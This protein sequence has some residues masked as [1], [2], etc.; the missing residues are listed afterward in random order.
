RRRI[1]R[2]P[3]ETYNVAQTV[4]FAWLRLLSHR[5]SLANWTVCATL[6]TAEPRKLD[7]DSLRYPGDGL[8]FQTVYSLKRETPITRRPYETYNVAQTVQFAWLRLLSHRRSLANW[9][10]CATLATAEP[11]KLDMDSLR[12]PGDGLQ[13]QTVYSLKRETPY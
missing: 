6:A 13:F 2:R 8:Q 10:V 11:R 1:T 7:M 5:R 12:Y 9:T 3:Y 4:Q